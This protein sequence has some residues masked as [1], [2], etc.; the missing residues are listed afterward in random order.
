M[1][2][3]ELYLQTGGSLEEV[4]TR[5]P[6]EKLLRKY[7]LRFPSDPSFS[8]FEK[9]VSESSWQEAFRAAHTLK[10]LCL[11]LGFRKPAE[12]AADL[13]EALRSGVAPADEAGFSA[14]VEILNTQY[15]ALIA[16]IDALDE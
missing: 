4:L 6:S 16:L 12:C 7:V 10:G 8:L 15:R 13:A 5:L 9:A 14:S 1:N 3:S 11:T 2:F